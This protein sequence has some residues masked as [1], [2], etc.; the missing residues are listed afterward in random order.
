MRIGIVGYGGFGQFL[1]QAWETLSSASVEAVADTDPTRS[2]ETARFHTSWQALITDEALDIISIATPPST[3]AAIACA[4]MEAGKHVL[5][6]KPLATT[7]SDA[8]R[9]LDAQ[10]RSGRVA[11]VNFM[12]RYNPV[13]E[14]L[15][16][17]S[18]DHTLGR[19]RRV[20]VENY[21]QDEALPP[22]HWFWDPTISGGIL[23][24]HAVHFIDLINGCTDAP[25]EQITGF[26]VRR[27]PGQEDRMGFTA[28]YGDGMT[29]SQYHAF[30]RPGFFERTTMHFIYDLAEIAVEGWIP[31]RGT[32]RA[33]VD[34][35]ALNAL[36][37]L[38]GFEMQRREAVQSLQDAS[39]PEGWGARTSSTAEHVTS[40]GEPYDVRYLVEGRFALPVSKAEAYADALRALMADLVQAARHQA[41]HPRVTLRDGLRSLRIAL[42][43]TES[44][45]G[46]RPRR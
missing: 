6:E 3:H 27:Q 34:D 36:S 4:A 22:D 29:C 38:P 23:V 12:L 45:H 30:S 2:P 7:L 46:T 1:H 16:R 17:W 5:I 13:V 25:P 31:L 44:A 15:H 32:V 9:I 41:P 20:L 10:Q 39:R 42:E 40:G 14:H 35:D 33:L 8:R 18:H 43:A 26:S 28:I 21:A 19:L 37:A 11:T 24:E